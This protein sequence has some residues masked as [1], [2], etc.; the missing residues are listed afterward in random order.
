M[1]EQL[2]QTL[3][4]ASGITKIRQ[5]HY[6]KEKLKASIPKKQRYKILQ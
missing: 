2:F 5:K 3:S 1:E 4:A 6:K